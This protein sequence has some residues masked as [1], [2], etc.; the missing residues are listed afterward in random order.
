MT[1]ETKFKLLQRCKT[2]LRSGGDPRNPTHIRHLQ[3]MFN[4]SRTTVVNYMK[5]AA[6]LIA[7][8]SE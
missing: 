3:A 2:W 7:E 4:V 8:E 6:S 5:V 1:N